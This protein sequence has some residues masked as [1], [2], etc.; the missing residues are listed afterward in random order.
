M[1][2]CYNHRTGV[3]CGFGGWD[4]EVGDRLVQFGS[5]YGMDPR[6][7]RVCCLIGDTAFVPSAAET[8]HFVLPNVPPIP[9]WVTARGGRTGVSKRLLSV[10][11]AE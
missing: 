6:L 8:F 10:R 3:C 5:K 2:Y 4:T 9:L 1:P 11:L 7:T